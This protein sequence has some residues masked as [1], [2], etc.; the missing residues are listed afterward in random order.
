MVFWYPKDVPVTILKADTFQAFVETHDHVFIHFAAAW[1]GYDRMFI[2]D[3]VN[4]ARQLGNK[5]HF[6]AVDIDEKENFNICV[7]HRVSSVPFIAIYKDGKIIE[8][9]A[10]YDY[11]MKQLAL[12]TTKRH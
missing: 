12:L 10:G 9:G 11:G 1:N 7:E 8:S 6:A 2:P 3:V 4:A 5:I